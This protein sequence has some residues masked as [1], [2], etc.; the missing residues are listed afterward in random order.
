[1]KYAGS[2]DVVVGSPI[3]GRTRNEVEELIGFFVNTLV[4]RAD[5][6]GDPSFREVLRRAREFTLGAYEH[7]EVPFERLVA[8]LQP[9]RSLSH[10]PLFQVV[11]ALENAG[12]GGAALPGLSVSGVGASMGAAK[13]DLS[14]TLSA[15]AQGLRGALNYS[16]DLFERGTALR[17]LSHLE[18][19]LEQVAADADVRLSRLEL[20]GGVERSLVLEEWNRTAAEVPADQ[21]IH[22]LFG[23]QA[24]RTPGAVALVF[25]GAELTYGELDTRANRLANYL[26]RLGVGPEARVGLCVE[27]SPEMVVAVLAVLKAGGAYVPLDPAYP[28][29]R[30]SFMLHDAA[31]PVLL[32]HSSLE[33]RLPAHPG[34]VVL[35]D[36]EANAIAREPAHAPESR[37]AAQNLAYV[38]Y[39]SG[40]T[41]RPKGAAIP[42]GGLARYLAWAGATYGAGNGRGAPVHSSLSFDLTVTSLFVPLLA[43]EAIVL[44]PDEGGEALASVLRS[45]GPFGFVKITPAHLS[46]LLE[47]LA[48]GEAARATSRFVVGGESLPGEVVARWAQVAP[49]VSITNEYG[50]TETVVGCCIHTL[51]ARET[52]A[53]PVPIGRPSPG[54]VLYALDGRMSPCPIGVPGELFVG[55]GQLGRGYLARPALTAERFVPDPFSAQPGARLY[56]TGDLARWRAD[57]NLEF[58]GRLDEQVKIRGFRIEL[59][60]VEGA[61]AAHAAVREARVVV[62]EDQPGER[63]LVAYV[64]GDADAEALRAHVRRSLPEYMVPAA[65]VFLDAL[66]LTTNGKLDRKALPAPEYAAGADRYVAP[67]TAGEEAL[68]GIWGEVLRLERVGAEESFF[69][70]GGH[71][72]LAIRLIERMR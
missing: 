46:L 3:A 67:R 45:S 21:C 50:P 52:T 29:D 55:G 62:R 30:L 38:I 58:M 4:L 48:P 13:F 23:E 5:L 39:T 10:S 12:D 71:S 34:R 40:S 63:R 54:T 15:T 28:A 1:S 35:L 25:E 8:E 72:L 70:L 41:G 43:G 49:E 44:A 60:E 47:Q 20:L 9:E 56:R 22:E 26:V 32:T 57:G 68:A 2:D 65:F 7:Q 61:V 24:A 18:R 19:V 31:V 53:G 27:R 11:F 64:V 33:Q 42:H 51:K 37:V 36:V 59:E 6:S 69:E 14:L 66:P 17:M 16:T